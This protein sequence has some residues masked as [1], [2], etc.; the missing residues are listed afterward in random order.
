M[1][2]YGCCLNMVAKQ[3]RGVGDEYLEAVDKM[4]YDYVEL[5]LAE[6]M[7]LSESE[8]SMIL[9]RLEELRINCEVCNNFFPAYMRLTGQRANLEE[10]LEYAAKALERAGQLG[11][12]RVVFGSGPAKRVPEKFPLEEGYLQVK[13]LLKGIGPMAQKREIIIC[14]EPLRREECNL[15]NTFAEAYGLAREVDHPSIRGLVD[16]F[17]MVSENEPTDHIKT[18]G[19]GFLKHIH[20]AKYQGRRFPIDFR[21]DKDGYVDFKNAI[22]EIGYGERISCEAYSGNFM[23]DGPAGLDFLKRYINDEVWEEESYE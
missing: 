8:F 1:M 19:R 15:I 4:G 23:A 22:K 9:R 17:H 6:I 5:P 18:Y 20:F 14:I 12:K 13:K 3:G 2:R 16:Y 10:N 21:Q 11:A 7:E